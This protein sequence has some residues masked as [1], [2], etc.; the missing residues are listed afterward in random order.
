MAVYHFSTQVTPQ[1]VATLLGMPATNVQ[2]E[3]GGADVTITVSM[4][5]SAQQETML[6][7]A[8]G[9]PRLRSKE[10]RLET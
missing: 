6:K 10:Q 3:R 9:L 7:D 2:V 5:L 8:I 1:D 4:P